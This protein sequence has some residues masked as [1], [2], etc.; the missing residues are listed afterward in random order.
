MVKF[1]RRGFIVVG[2]SFLVSSCTSFAF[3]SATKPN[4][5]NQA[6]IL[7]KINQ[8]R[9]ANGVKPFGYN[10]KLEKA[11]KI[12]S[13]L[14][15]SKNKMSHEIGG[16]LCERVSKVGYFGAVGENLGNGYQTLEEVIEGW[17]ASPGHRAT[18]LSKKFSEFGLAQA[19]AIT[20]NGSTRYYWTLIA[21][22]SAKAWLN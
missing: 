3:D 2:A 7:Q 16:T 5:L 14:M 4:Q 8:A 1:N 17:L 20:P 9:A 6:I 22:G 21:G 12:H 11:T 10:L 19:L 18:L 13:N 15:A